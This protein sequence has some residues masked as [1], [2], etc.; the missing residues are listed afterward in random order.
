MVDLT[1]RMAAVRKD[2][3]AAARALVRAA[4]VP[5]PAGIEADDGAADRWGGAD[6]GHR[7]W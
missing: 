4:V 3:E 6:R 7:S 1:D 5:V 2:S